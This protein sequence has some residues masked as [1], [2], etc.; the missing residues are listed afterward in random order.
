MNTEKNEFFKRMY[1]LIGKK[2]EDEPFQFNIP[3]HFEWNI[4]LDDLPKKTVQALQA[5]RTECRTVLKSAK[6]FKT[7]KHSVAD[8]AKTVFD[9]LPLPL[10]EVQVHRTQDIIRYRATVTV[11]EIGIHVSLRHI[12]TSED[13]GDLS[14]VNQSKS[15]MAL[16][17]DVRAMMNRIVQGDTFIYDR[18]IDIIGNIVE[19]TYLSRDA[20]D[21][22]VIKA[23]DRIPDALLFAILHA[24][25]ATLMPLLKPDYRPLYVPALRL[26]KDNQDADKQRT[27]LSSTLG[28][29]A[30]ARDPNTIY[31]AAL[32][33]AIQDA[34]GLKALQQ[35]EGMPVLVQITKPKLQAELTNLLQCAQCSL[36]ASGRQ[37]HPLKTVPILAGGH[38]PPMHAALVLD[39]NAV[40]T[41]RPGDIAL[42]R[43]RFKKRMQF[44]DQVVRQF[45]RGLT[46]FALDGQN[47]P[48]A[49]FLRMV[50]IFASV[51]FRQEAHQQALIERAEHTLGLVQEQQDQQLA[52]FEHAAAVLQKFDSYQDLVADSVN[53]LQPGQLG[54]QYRKDNGIRYVAFKKT[55]DFPAFCEK[56]L[57]L[58]EKDANEFCRYLLQKN[59]IND[60]RNNVR[61]RS[62]QSRSHVLIPAEYC[63]A[64]QQNG[65]NN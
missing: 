34:E 30:L 7:L 64:P 52:R 47:Y 17:G 1:R 54:F 16:V 5:Y 22:E 18:R 46:G 51:L 12:T 56:K 2:L 26:L 44:P 20:N 24:M 28:G 48:D 39:W 19:N 10:P 62:G 6:K 58:E 36:S 43:E 3:T 11:H 15:E 13:A 40:I 57:G 9:L 61:G 32:Q 31:P 60:L 38:L 33:M 65:G 23:I 53:E 14:G 8:S 29:F 45:Q 27:I 50:R 63:G 21:S 41:A 49:Y 42:L 25:L 59:I 35:V 55:E 4:P 37:T